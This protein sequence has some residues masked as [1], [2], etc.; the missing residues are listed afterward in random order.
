MHLNLLICFVLVSVLDSSSALPFIARRGTSSE[1]LAPRATYS[2]VPIDGSGDNS[3]STETGGGTAV[4][5]V[6]VTPTPST[7]T[8]FE[9]SPPVTDTIVITANPATHTISTTVSIVDIQSTTDIVTTTVTEDDNAP[10]STAAYPGTVSIV[11]FTSAFSTT[12]SIPT[13]S[14]TPTST[15]ATSAPS[16]TE[17]S[18]QP[19]ISTSTSSA[20]VWTTPIPTSNWVW[21]S[22]TSYDDGLWHT[23]YPP[24]N[25]TV[26][27]RFARQQ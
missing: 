15:V 12:S 20:A 25:G 10:T 19:T 16:I 14:P 5:T 8:I 26:S 21:S 4:E 27:R 6:V 1:W 22:S 13:N 23:T 7:K 3:G 24:W 11:T 18:P 9:T 2:V 17:T